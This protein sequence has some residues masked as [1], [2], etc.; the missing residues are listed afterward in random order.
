MDASARRGSW[1]KASNAAR[2]MP[3]SLI[4]HHERMIVNREHVGDGVNAA[5]QCVAPFRTIDLQNCVLF[6]LKSDTYEDTYSNIEKSIREQLCQSCSMM[7]PIRA[8]VSVTGSF[9]CLPT[10]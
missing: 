10:S 2:L 6:C 5:D 7:L 9:S 8:G 4:P 3:A 1:F